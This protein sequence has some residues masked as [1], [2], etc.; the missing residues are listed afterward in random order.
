[1]DAGRRRRKSLG[2]RKQ[3]AV[4]NKARRKK[5]R[6]QNPR[7]GR[8]SVNVANQTFY[9]IRFSP[10]PAVFIVFIAVASISYLGLHCGLYN[11]LRHAGKKGWLAFIPVAYVFVWLEIIHKPQW[12]FVML[13]IPGVNLF[14]AAR[15][16]A[17][18]ARCY[19]KNS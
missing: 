11:L 3:S 15:M 4:G 7:N 9:I 5:T 10:M 1:M 18:T 17:D 16:I 12:W 2:N 19:N 13:L 14:F 6:K 8:L